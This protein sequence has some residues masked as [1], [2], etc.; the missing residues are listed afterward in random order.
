MPKE[1]VSQEEMD[2]IA[3]F[4]TEV[5]EEFLE[6]NKDFK[7]IEREIII[8]ALA[9]A[10]SNRIE[11]IDLDDNDKGAVAA[12]I[13]EGLCDIHKGPLAFHREFLKT[14][15]EQKASTIH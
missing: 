11:Q 1:L 5:I 9:Q 10:V 12:T 2:E 3:P 15:I 4:V 14:L 13:I 8:Y 7:G 6:G